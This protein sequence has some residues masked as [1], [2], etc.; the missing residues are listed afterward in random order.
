[1]SSAASVTKVSSLQLL[2]VRT[3]QLLTSLRP[4]NYDFDKDILGDEDCLY[5]TVWAPANATGL[6]VMFWLGTLSPLPLCFLPQR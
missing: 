4:T 3:E 5:V 1:M 2:F 6:P